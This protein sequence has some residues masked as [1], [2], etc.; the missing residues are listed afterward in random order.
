LIPKQIF[1][2]WPSDDIWNIDHTLVHIGLHN[3]R[4]LN[5]DYTIHIFNDEEVRQDLKQSLDAN[6]FYSIE[7]SPI[8]QQIDLWRLVKLYISG[9]VYCDMDRVHD[10]PLHI[11]N[12]VK[13][14]LPMCG[15][16]GF[17]HDFMAT[18]PLNPIFLKAAEMNLS[19]RQMGFNHTYLLGPQTYMHAITECL[20]G[21]QIE[22]N[23]GTEMLDYLK[24]IIEETNFIES[25]Q[26]IPPLFTITSKNSWNLTIQEH[27]RLKRE[28]YSISGLTHWTGEW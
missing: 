12:H 9:G 16:V 3:L 25:V 1:L 24:E 7:N 6:D 17:S 20:I 4:D 5:P 26:E 14:V 22:V 11:E 2:S 23:P 18:E 13:C 15:E 10:T 28:L 19:R 8:V 21:Q 27:E